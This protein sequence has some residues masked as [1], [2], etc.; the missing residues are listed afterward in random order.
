MSEDLRRILRRFYICTVFTTI[1]TLRQ[2]LTRVKD[3]DSPLSKAV[4]VYRVL[5]VCSC[6]KEY[7][8]ETKRALGTHVKELQ[9]ATRMEETEKS[10]IAEHAWAEQHQAIWDQT[11]VIE[12]AKSANILRIKEAF[13]IM[14]AEK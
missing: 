8:D 3:V 12:Q 9:S 2:Q 13:C 11:L 6:K 5:H 4:V 1:S 10:T 14:M 7:I